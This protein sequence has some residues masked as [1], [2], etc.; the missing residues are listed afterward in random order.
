[1]TA[2]R[3]GLLAEFDGGFADAPM[4]ADSRSPSALHQGSKRRRSS[5]PSLNGGA[6]ASDDLGL[7]GTLS[8]MF[9]HLGMLPSAGSIGLRVDVLLHL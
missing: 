4:G 5:L 6:S 3:A 7:A 8:T 2:E 9:D 1:M